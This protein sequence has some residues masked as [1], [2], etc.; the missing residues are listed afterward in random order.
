MV[1]ASNWSDPFVLCDCRLNGPS[2]YIHCVPMHRP[3]AVEGII[4]QAR[5][6]TNDPEESA[7]RQE[8]QKAVFEPESW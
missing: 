4:G 8:G 7:V 5:G 1:A 3:S 6:V 2:R